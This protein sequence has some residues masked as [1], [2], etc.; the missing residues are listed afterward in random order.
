[1]FSYLHPSLSD[2]PRGDY[3]DSLFVS[4]GRCAVLR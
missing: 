3:K 1:M 4:V 2:R